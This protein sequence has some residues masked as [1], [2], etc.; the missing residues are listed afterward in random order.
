MTIF[1]DNFSDNSKN[2]LEKDT[3]EVS[4]QVENGGYIIEHRQDSGWWGTWRSFNN[5]TQ[6]DLG[7]KIKIQ[8]ILGASDSFYGIAW[9]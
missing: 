9:G 1:S 2:W 4:L 5:H 6:N 8:R 3:D 7:I